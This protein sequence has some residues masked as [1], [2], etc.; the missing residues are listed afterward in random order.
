MENPAESEKSIIKKQ[1][2]KEEHSSLYKD[3]SPVSDADSDGKYSEALNFAMANNQVRNI[4]LTGPYGSG[5]SSVLR[6]FDNNSD[7]KFLNISLASFDEEEKVEDILIERSIIQQMFY[8]EHS[9][10]LPFSRFKRISVPKNALLKSAMFFAW[11]A[12]VIF[13]F[14][15][16][17]SLFEISIFSGIYWVAVV[18][19]TLAIFFPV[20]WGAS[21]YK[22]AFGFS[23]KKLSITNAEIELDGVPE[24]SILNKYLD[25]IIYFFQV[26]QY[27]IVVIEDLDRFGSPDIFVK[28]REINKLIND[29]D[30]TSGKIKFI[31][32]LKDDMFANSDRAKFFDFIIPV[33]PII[34]ESNSLEKMMERLENDAFPN[35]INKQF[36]REVSF[37]IYDMRLIHNI[38]NEFLIYQFKLG[39]EKLDKTKLLAMMIY[40]NV[41]P[42][43]F[44]RLHNRTGTLYTICKSR[45][46]LVKSLREDLNQNIARIKK[47]ISDSTAESARNTTELIQ[48]FLGMVVSQDNVN[49]PVLGMYIGGSPKL[50]S[51]LL[52]WDVFKELTSETNISMVI[53]DPHYNNRKQKL[54]LNKSF[55][56]LEAEF[57]NQFTITQRKRLIEN[58]SADS[59]RKLLAEIENLEGKSSSVSHLQLYE[60]IFQTGEQI[61]ETLS[62]NKIEN[63]DLLLYL[64]RDGYLDETH[65][66]YISNFHEGRTTHQDRDFILTIRNYA[67]PDP[68]QQ[69]DTPIEVCET[70]RA[71]DFKHHYVLNVNLFDYLLENKNV[72]E[73]QVRLI[74]AVDF[75]LNN[76]EE[77]AEFF[78]AYWDVGGNKDLLIQEIAKRWPDYASAVINHYQDSNHLP[79]ILR[80]VSPEYIA[81]AMNSNEAITDYL[82]KNGHWMYAPNIVGSEDYSVLKLL[83][84]KFNDLTLINENRDLLDYVHTENLYEINSENIV[85]LLETYSGANQSDLKSEN[86]STLCIN[87]SDNLK[88]YINENITKYIERVFLK[89]PENTKEHVEYIIKLLENNMISNDLKEQI[90]KKQEYI[91]STLVNLSSEFWTLVLLEDKIE[92]SWD[93]IFKYWEYAEKE[94]DED[95]KLL[96]QEIL[97]DF[98]G[99]SDSVSRL[100]EKKES[101]NDMKDDD[102]LNISRFILNNGKLSDENYSQL[103]KC[104]LVTWK[105]F[106][107]DIS[108]SKHII[109][110]KEKKVRLNESTFGFALEDDELLPIL[111]R[112]SIYTYITNR[113]KYPVTDRV[114]DKLLSFDISNE[115]KIK[116]ALDATLEGVEYSE[117][118]AQT[119]GDLVLLPKV[120]VSRFDNDIAQALVI[121]ARNEEYSIR[122]LTKF[123]P[124]LAKMDVINTLAELPLPYRNMAS[125]GKRPKIPFTDDNLAFVTKLK[126]HGII[127]KHTTEN[128]YIRIS[129]FKRQW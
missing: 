88:K 16:W 129:T 22:S 62:E 18:L 127:S 78:N 29:N 96:K 39:S 92:V 79:L 53:N 47:E 49:Q 111:I 109:L 128:K 51:Q 27:D 44:E 32:A 114:R 118:Y 24:S 5:K 86:Y 123:V 37:Y 57:D 116:I 102:V 28:L 77:A 12:A 81:K 107:S 11:V 65:D 4:A 9:D 2:P 108:K 73:N 105:G 121:R 48:L 99:T 113:D 6:T 59:R 31:Y 42:E 8:G 15:N 119:I 52:D 68:R 26:T 124:Q 45:P 100:I 93:N 56:Q 63:K 41:Y 85:L 64:I 35:T 61:E 104:S 40:K 110:A 89:L 33:V 54:A 34:N 46:L 20:L 83:K 97:T 17:G 3:L 115:I 76:F 36:L 10:K 90:I 71:S 70:M 106:P 67:Q 58:K 60:L 1:D 103:I 69:I 23:F 21:I 72:Y 14:K 117:H 19:I 55:K 13:L 125:F 50:F 74:G 43:D 7:Y 25:E 126:A 66:L 91:F 84:V 30:K 120:D 75:I 98:L 87:G 38:F 95:E 101:L 82:A 94:E 122:L 112:E 80:Y